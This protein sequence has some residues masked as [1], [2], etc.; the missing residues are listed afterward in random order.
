M[1]RATDTSTLMEPRVATKACV[2]GC[3]RLA[4]TAS[5]A[6]LPLPG[7]RAARSIALVVLLQGG[8]NVG[9]AQEAADG[10]VAVWRLGASAAVS[11]TDNARA[12]SADQQSGVGA[13]I[14]FDAQLTLPFRRL[15][16]FV[17]YS[18]QRIAGLSDSTT[19]RQQSNLQSGLNAE[20]IESLAFLDLSAAYGAQLGSVFGST[21]RSLL[22][23]NS[24]R[25]DTASF[26]VS[27][28]VR[29]RIGDGGGAE[30]R[31]TDST[32]RVS[33]SEVGDIRTQA[34][35][36]VVDS[37]VRAR[38][39]T[40]KGQ[41]YG[42]RYEPAEG[43]RTTDASARADVGWAFDADTVVSVIA[44]REGNDFDSTRRIYNDLYG[45]G[46]DYR[47]NQRT[48]FYAEALNRFFGT[49]HSVSL[50]YRMPQFALIGTSIRT[51]TRPGIG[52][53]GAVAV[54]SGSAFDVL[55]LQLA[56][57]EPDADRRRILAQ[58]LLTANGIDPAQPINPSLLTSGVLLTESHS[59]SAIWTGSRNTVTVL[60]NGGSNRRIES[61]VSLPV[62][63][64]FQTEERIDQQGAQLIWLRRLTPA[65]DLSAA[66][67]WTRAEGSLTQLRSTT[68]TGQLRWSRRIGDR[69]VLAVSASHERFNE[70]AGI[71]YRVNVLTGEYRIRF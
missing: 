41:A 44:G 3:F 8:L 18:I 30:A 10:R 24:N 15:R 66:V 22:V 35:V 9:F 33:G 68:R 69:S 2:S 55:Y 65:D 21:E 57:V 42:A 51:N 49:G 29:M 53:A 19:N 50:S 31:L 28:S 37:G 5:R 63:D 14:G 70:V 4:R 26:T 45:L 60:V 54:S 7:H 39:L 71:S 11:A 47:P 20:V 34:G 27:P 56:S 52:L 38:S 23:E 59:L 12:S 40:W 46:F 67:G 43:R 58:D 13:E 32:T 17:D 25:L 48:R 16:G 62:G 36:L 6:V 61:L 64:Q 1:V